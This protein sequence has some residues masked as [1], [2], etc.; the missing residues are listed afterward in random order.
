MKECKCKKANR[1]I[2]LTKENRYEL[3]KE[4]EPEIYETTC[5]FQIEEADSYFCVNY[6]GKYK[7]YY[8]YDHWYVEEE[9]GCEYPR[10]NKYTENDF[11]EEYDLMESED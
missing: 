9:T 6:Y 1:C 11:Y 2:W 10:F 7:T 4:A 8:Y 3:L 5:D